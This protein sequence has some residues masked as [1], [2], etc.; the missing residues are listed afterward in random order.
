MVIVEI[1]LQS[2]RLLAMELERVNPLLTLTQ[3]DTLKVKPQGILLN[4]QM[5]RF[6][7]NPTFKTMF[8]VP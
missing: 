8:H 7:T 2:L 3:L 6:N 5:G 4:R 1:G